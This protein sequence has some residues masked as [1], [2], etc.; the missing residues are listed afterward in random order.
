MAG[1]KTRKPY[2]TL[3]ATLL[4]LRLIPPDTAFN[5]RAAAYAK[6]AQKHAA[7]RA[8]VAKQKGLKHDD[9]D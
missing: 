5:R 9:V 4:R 3:Q 8:W 1:R 7:V 2:K 6:Q